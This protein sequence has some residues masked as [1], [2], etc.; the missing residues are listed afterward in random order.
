MLFPEAAM[1]GLPGDEEGEIAA[2]ALA[3]LVPHLDAC[4]ALVVGPGM[5]RCSH[6]GDLVAR[7]LRDVSATTAVLLDAGAL[8]ALRGKAAAVKALGG[9]VVLT[10]HHGELAALTVS[11]RRRLRAIRRGPRSMPPPRS[12]R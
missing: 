3:V 12:M 9:R 7:L 5:M 11:T 6:T 10:P 4:D 1:I 8:T 2:E